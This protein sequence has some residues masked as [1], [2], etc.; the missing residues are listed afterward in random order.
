MK[1]SDPATPLSLSSSSIVSKAFALLFARQIL[2]LI[3]M[4]AGCWKVFELGP[5]GHVERFFLPF[6]EKSFLPVWSL[7]LVG[8]VVPLL[9]LIG[10]ALLIVGYQRLWSLVALGGVL[11]LVTFGHLLDKPLY[12]LHIHVLP[13][14]GLVLFL[15][16]SEASLDRWSLDE[17]CR[18]RRLKSL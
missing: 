14:L 8:S 11:V 2:G 6:A 1:P 7:W 3:F 15:L 10:G 17:W 4:V 12:E 16:M 18:R 5:V 9:E 13:R